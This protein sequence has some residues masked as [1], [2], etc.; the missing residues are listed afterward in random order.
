MEHYNEQLEKNLLEAIKE[1]EAADKQLLSLEIVIGIFASVI[2]FAT[3][4]VASFVQMEDW[5]RIVL[6]L[7][8]LIPFI[9]GMMFALKIEQKAGYYECGN[10]HHRYVPSFGSVCF[11]MH[12]NRTRR[13]KCPKCNKRSWHKKRIS[14]E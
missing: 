7:V 6:I 14:K 2:L 1:K 4:F 11:S 12:V 3:V 9:V 8:A 5:L 13:M 10:C